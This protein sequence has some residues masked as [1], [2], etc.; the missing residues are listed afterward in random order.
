LRP[1]GQY[2]KIDKLLH[3]QVTCVIHC[4][5][6]SPSGP[7]P[8]DAVQVDL[9]PTL[10]HLLGA[11]DIPTCFFGRNLLASPRAKKSLISKGG[12]ALDDNFGVTDEGDDFTAY[13]LKDHKEVADCPLKEETKR[14][15]KLV[16]DFL[17]LDLVPK[18]RETKY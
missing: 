10:V 3:D 8:K 18:V 15:F 4:P 16:Y 1:D 5:G 13:S 7:L 14:W 11:Q 12:Y 2:D 9:V 17:R 6:D